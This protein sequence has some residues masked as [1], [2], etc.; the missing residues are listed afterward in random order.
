MGAL[1]WWTTT[2]GSVV[3]SGRGF[4]TV[5][6]VEVGVRRRSDR[7]AGFDAGFLRG[8][9]GEVGRRADDDGWCY[10]LSEVWATAND[11]CSRAKP[12]SIASLRWPC[13]CSFE[14]DYTVAKGRQ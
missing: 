12:V 14:P 9:D 7:V 2:G 3:L 11:G 6:D 13:S 8:G 10:V 5:W 4:G 1:C